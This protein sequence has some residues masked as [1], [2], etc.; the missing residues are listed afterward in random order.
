MELR[1]E[2]PSGLR[3]G[4]RKTWDSAWVGGKEVLCTGHELESGGGREVRLHLQV[5]GH[6]V[7][8]LRVWGKALV[9]PGSTASTL[10]ECQ[11]K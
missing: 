4:N 10:R 7:P 1:S 3:L 6:P 5:K 11:T 9:A 2:P 8:E